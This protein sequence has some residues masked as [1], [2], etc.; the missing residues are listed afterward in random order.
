[1]GGEKARR[2]QGN[3]EGGGKF[4]PGLSLYFRAQLPLNYNTYKLV[5]LSKAS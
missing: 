2:N 1:M 3:G 5:Q 4:T